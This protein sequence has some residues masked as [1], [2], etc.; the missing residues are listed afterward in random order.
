M[1]PTLQY[2]QKNMWKVGRWLSDAVNDPF[3][4]LYYRSLFI[5]CFAPITVQGFWSSY[6][7]VTL[8]CFVN[9]GRPIA[10]HLF[11][12]PLS[13]WV[14]PSPSLFPSLPSTV[15]PPLTPFQDKLLYF[16]HK[17]F[18]FYCILFYLVF[19]VLFKF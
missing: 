8:L 17:F 12:G 16:L 6:T 11:F 19:L 3:L 13:P 2:I 15:S 14:P 1:M 9:D 18:V 7:P 5:T 4:Y 10:A